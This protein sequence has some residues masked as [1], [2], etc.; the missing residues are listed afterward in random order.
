MQDDVRVRR[1]CCPARRYQNLAAHA[2]VDHHRLARIKFAEQ[3]FAAATST[4]N[5]DAR[6][7]V[8]QG[9]AAGAPN[10]AQATDLDA[11]DAPADNVLRQPASNGFDLG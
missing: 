1:P 8:D 4:L 3:I 5:H 9:L 7:P 6:K 10:S 2:Q 11:F